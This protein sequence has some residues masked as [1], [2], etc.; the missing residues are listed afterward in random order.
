MTPSDFEAKFGTNQSALRAY[1][2]KRWRNHLHNGPWVL[3]QEMVADACEHFGV[4][5]GARRAIT[6]PSIGARAGQARSAA[7]KGTPNPSSGTAPGLHRPVLE[8]ARSAGIQLALGYA[9]PWLSRRGHLEERIKRDIPTDVMTALVRIHRE[10]G[11]DAAI[12]ASKRLGSVPIP[13]LI[14]LHTG[15]I[16]EIDESQHFTSARLQSFDYYPE[17]VRLGYDRQEYVGFVKHWRARGDRGF[18][19]RVAKDFPRPGGRQAQRA[20][21]DALRDLLAPTFTRYP[22]IRI[23]VPDRNLGDVVKRLQ[24]ALAGLQ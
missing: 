3:T 9:V 16:I 24:A 10:L 15:C 5:M 13:D 18:A 14:H 20:Y 22:V 21:N 2:R 23:A 11:G 12:L 8:L 7:P 4:S 19:H 17:S 6:P 1:L